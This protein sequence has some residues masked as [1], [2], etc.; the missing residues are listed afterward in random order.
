M[1]NPSNILVAV[2][3]VTA[4]MVA[5]SAFGQSV[6]TFQTIRIER[7]QAP[8][9]YLN[10]TP[11]SSAITPYTLTWPT[12]APLSGQALVVTG[13]GP[14]QLSWGFV[15]GGT[16]EL[17]STVDGGIRRVSTAT[18]GGIVGNVGRY[19]ND[20]QGSR[21]N[22]AQSATGAYSLV[23]GG[24]NNTASGE[25]AIVM[26]GDGNTSSGQY[27]L[28]GGG[29]QNTATGIG[30]SVLGGY[31]N[32]NA[33]PWAS[34]V[35][36]ENNTIN[37]T[38]ANGFIGGGSG[39]TL[40]GTHAAVLGG[41]SNTVAGAF[42]VVLGGNNNQASD[43]GA[44][45]GA[46]E[47]NKATG[48]YSGVVAGSNNTS[49]GRYSF[50]G[51]GSQN[52][53][54]GNWSAIGG[55]NTNSASGLYA[56]LGG[57]GSNTANGDYATVSGGN[58]ITITSGA[59]NAISGGRTNSISTGSYSWIGGGQSNTINASYAAIPGGRNMTIDVGGD[60]SFG[61]NSGGTAMTISNSNAFVIANADLWLANNDN[62]ARE[63]RFYEN[64]SA[65]G[66]FPGSANYVA[67]KAPNSTFN[68]LN[69]TYT[70]PDR[71]GTQGQVLR[72][73]A[74]PSTTAANLEW[75]SVPTIMAATIDV[76]ADGQAITAAQLDNL[77]YARL[78]CN[79]LPANRTITI[80]NGV[81][82]GQVIV[83]RAVGSGDVTYGFE[84][85]DGLFDNVV[86]DGNALLADGD[87]I[88]L[89]W[90]GTSGLWVETMRSDNQ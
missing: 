37:A 22:G 50:V 74:S 42:G 29:S 87:T 49:S 34:I 90:D 88:T 17:A 75:G 70:L 38:G 1:K 8:G 5:P 66:T 28:V 41:Q 21:T 73:A 76:T 64:N 85:E 31:S 16:L 13:S 71:V 84:L 10:I 89:I 12:T 51:G 59:Y 86:L 43:S 15:G 25:Y 2:S 55:G 27:A 56:V 77:T 65:A 3:L 19:A 44:V 32:D 36:G 60:G 67:F 46:G 61:W 52:T 79:G 20:F 7:P 23:G 9:V 68:N 4:V 40:I 80:P 47:Q 14:Y 18:E 78:S 35:G 33:G 6:Q 53:A 45:V 72:I 24:K 30:S 48:V 83:L 69:N 57:G 11:P 63:M 26:G 58:Q 39:N 82:N 54:S 62:S 81:N